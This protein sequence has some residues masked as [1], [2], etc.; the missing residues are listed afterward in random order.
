MRVENTPALNAITESTIRFF[1]SEEFTENRT[2]FWTPMQYPRKNIWKL[3]HNVGNRVS[4]K[5]SHTFNIGSLFGNK[6]AL[7]IQPPQNH[8]LK[9][10]IQLGTEFIMKFEYLLR[11]SSSNIVCNLPCFFSLFSHFQVVS[12][13]QYTQSTE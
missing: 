12:I 2:H 9:N 4:D 10:Q 3:L 13:V 6:Y 5:Y 1:Y 11:F 8:R 7:R